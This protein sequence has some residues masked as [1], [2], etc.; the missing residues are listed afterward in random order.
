MKMK[1]IRKSLEPV[2]KSKAAIETSYEP[3]D[4]GRRVTLKFRSDIPM[5]ALDFGLALI[6]F[7]NEFVAMTYKDK[8]N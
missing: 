8:K 4:D 6:D 2:P 3:S 5:N 1:D 7:V